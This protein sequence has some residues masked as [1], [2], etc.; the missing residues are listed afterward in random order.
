VEGPNTITIGAVDAL[1]NVATPLVM[2]IT[3]DTVVPNLRITTDSHVSV[4][5]DHASIAG[6]TDPSMTVRV[7]VTYGAYSKTYTA[8]TGPTGAWAFDLELPQIG[9][10]TVVVT[11]EDAAGNRAV[12]TLTFER[13]RPKPVV[14]PPEEGHWLQDNWVY[15]VLLASIVTSLLVIL[16]IMVPS[17]RRRDARRRIHEA[18]IAARETREAE[19]EAAQGTEGE[20]EAGGEGGAEDGEAKAAG[21][22][23]AAGGKG[24]DSHSAGGGWEEYE[25]SGEGSEETDD[26]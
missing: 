13:T 17:R 9:N 14:P 4:D 11:V 19:A 10:H 16:I 7:T 21:G 23:D 6:T 26:D 24:A 1:G 15:L 25:E 5:V 20:G 2:N 3:L 12:D 18:N 22:A 8:V